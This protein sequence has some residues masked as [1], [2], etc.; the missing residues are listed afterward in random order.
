MKAATSPCQ[1]LDHPI[2]CDNEGMRRA[3]TVY[4]ALAAF[5][6]LAFAESFTKFTRG[7]F[8]VLTDA[9]AHTGRETMVRFEQFRHA[10]G[11]VLGEPD[12]QTPLPVRIFV[13]KNSR[14][15]ASPGPISE[16]R[17]HYSIVLDEK[18]VPSPELYRALTRL[19]LQSNSAQMPPAFER[20]LIEFFSTF[21]VNGIRITAG[22]PPT[23]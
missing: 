22:T 15:W 14:G 9:S 18:S 21:E 23:K 4:C 20:G 13:F 12:L 2:P 5:A 3:S 16:G 10:L 8:E 7:P 1:S 17:D 11:Q 19:F 6:T